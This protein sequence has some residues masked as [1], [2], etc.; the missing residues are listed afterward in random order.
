MTEAISAGGDTDSMASMVGALVGANC[1]LKND[2]LED[3]IPSEWIDFC[4]EFG[5][6]LKFGKEFFIAAQ[7]AQKVR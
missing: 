6:T 5:E 3:I 7:G 1:G 2:K 4:P